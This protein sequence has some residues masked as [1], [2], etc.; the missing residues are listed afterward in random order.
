MLD[1]IENENNDIELNGKVVVR[2]Y[3]LSDNDFLRFANELRNAT[4]QYRVSTIYALSGY[5]SD[6]EDFISYEKNQLRQTN[7][8][9]FNK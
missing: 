5:V 7:Y 4:R 3:N 8:N 2:G 6:V 9:A 1:F